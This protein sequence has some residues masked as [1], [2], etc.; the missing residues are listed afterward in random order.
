MTAS[1]FLLTV[2]ITVCVTDSKFDV[3]V[4]VNVT[5]R[6]RL[7]ASSTVPLAGEYTKFPAVADD[8]FN[9][10]AESAVP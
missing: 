6:V 1:D 5:E 4:G 8:A 9:C 2:M 7:P 3:S 10:V